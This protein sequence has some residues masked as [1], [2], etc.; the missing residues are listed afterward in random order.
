MEA[1]DLNKCMHNVL[2]DLEVQIKETGGIVKWNDLPTV[3]G[4]AAHLSRLLLNLIDN[5]LKFHGEKTPIVNV[6]AQKNC[7]MWEISI[8]DNGIG[9]EKN[10]LERIFTPFEKLHG[11]SE[12]A[13][14]GAG[15]SICRKIIQRHGG[16]IKTESTPGKGSRFKF[17]LKA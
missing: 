7:Y 6:S 16:E 3:Q 14:S 1:V 9:I 13:G 12:Y 10:Y 17:T 8:D 2:R 4:D 15:L 5:A 11:S